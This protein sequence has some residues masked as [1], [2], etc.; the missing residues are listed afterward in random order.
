[1]HRKEVEERRPIVRWRFNFYSFEY[2]KSN[3]NKDNVSNITLRNGTIS[4]I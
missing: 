3:D 2:E 4:A 1:M